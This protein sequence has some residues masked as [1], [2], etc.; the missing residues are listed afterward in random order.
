MQ[1]LSLKSIYKQTKG[2]SH[3]STLDQLPLWAAAPDSLSSDEE[4][5]S[6]SKPSLLLGIKSAIKSGSIAINLVGKCAKAPK[7]R[8]SSAKSTPLSILKIS[9]AVSSVQK[10]D[11]MGTKRA[12][13]P[14]ESLVELNS[15]KRLKTDESPPNTQ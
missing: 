6:T 4:G 8:K 11:G 12:T 14:E 7:V 1:Q 10:L 15:S 5:N 9:S 2:G 13:P 3:L